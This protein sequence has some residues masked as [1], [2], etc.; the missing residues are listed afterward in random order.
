MCGDSDA[1][2]IPPGITD[3]DD[4]VDARGIRVDRHRVVRD[5]DRGPCAE[6]NDNHD[7]TD[8]GR[9]APQGRV[10][11]D[12]EVRLLPV[13][14]DIGRECRARRALPRRVDRSLGDMRR[15]RR[16][17]R[18]LGVRHI[19]R[20]VRDESLRP[21]CRG[22][23]LAQREYVRVRATDG[24]GPVRGRVL[25]IARVSM[26]R[27]RRLWRGNA[28]LERGRHHPTRPIVRAAHG[29]DRRVFVHLGISRYARYTTVLLGFGGG[30]ICHRR[31][32]HREGD[33]VRLNLP[34]MKLS[35]AAQA[36]RGDILYSRLDIFALMIV[37]YD[38]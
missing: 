34:P 35:H 5:V 2:N 18:S 3:I 11:E 22:R 37:V 16:V 25:P 6:T 17:R 33:A 32:S 26:H 21:A 7:A 10:R 29:I 4:G 13:R 30:G 23:R 28:V 38:E 27:R 9:A 19:R 12:V 1:E 14:A 8:H 24:I 36:C 20:P 15:P 31:V